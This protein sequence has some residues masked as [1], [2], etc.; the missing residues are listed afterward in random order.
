LKTILLTGY[1]GFIGR[2]LYQVL[3][4]RGYNVFGF[5]KDSTIK[6]I[7]ESLKAL[8]LTIRHQT[9][10]VHQGAITDT[11]FKDN[12]EMMRNNYLFSKELFDLALEEEV[13]VVY[14]SSAAVYGDGHKKYPINVYGWSKYASELYG[15]REFS[16]NSLIRSSLMTPRFVALRY[17]NVFGPGEEQKGRMASIAYQSMVRGEMN[18]FPKKPQRD[19][20]YIDD[21]VSANVHAIEN[22]NVSTGYYEVGSGKSH[23][24][25]YVCECL[26]IPFTITEENL[27]PKGYQFKTQSNADNWMPGWTPQCNLKE[28]LESYKKY[29]EATNDKKKK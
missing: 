21:I 5:D 1:K 14:A 7:E 16:N 11:L 4:N 29:F 9:T 19:F 25:E 17:F 15:I 18:L 24:F 26:D 6:D 20:V 8:P 22:S 3:T 12:S 27:I 10:I 28:S 13:N 23:T 2:R